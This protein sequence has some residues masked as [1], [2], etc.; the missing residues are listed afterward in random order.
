MENVFLDG[1]VRIL[2][3]RSL[4]QDLCPWFMENLGYLP[5]LKK[6]G[7]NIFILKLKEKT[8]EVNGYGELTRLLFG[9]AEN[10][11]NIPLPFPDDLSYI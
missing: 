7:D 10:S 9:G 5:S 2:N 3:E 1:T 8:I 11:L 6:I 4:F